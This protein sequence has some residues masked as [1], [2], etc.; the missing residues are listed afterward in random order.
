MTR[1]RRED[2]MASKV[3]QEAGRSVRSMAGDLGCDESSLRYRLGRLRSGKEDGRRRQPEACAPW[4]EQIAA[5][6]SALFDAEASSADARA[7]FEIRAR[8][9]GPQQLDALGKVQRQHRAGERILEAV[10]GRPAGLVGTGLAVA[11]VVGDGLDQ[12]VGLGAL[13]G[14]DIGFGT[15]F[16]A[17]FGA[18][19]QLAILSAE[20]YIRTP[21]ARRGTA[22][23]IRLERPFSCRSR[24]HISPL[25]T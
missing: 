17:P 21:T 1:L 11:D 4:A 14:A 7:A 13:R 24:Q 16:G 15:H 20:R 22:R 25:T 9:H 5:C 2:V 12:R 6:A 10:V 3:F 8:D 19:G 23:S 18:K